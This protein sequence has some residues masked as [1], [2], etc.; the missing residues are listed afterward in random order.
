M[1]PDRGDLRQSAYGPPVASCRSLWMHP[2]AHARTACPNKIKGIPYKIQRGWWTKSRTEQQQHLESNAHRVPELLATTLHDSRRGSLRGRVGSWC[3]VHSCDY[4][5]KGEPGSKGRA[6][7]RSL[8]DGGGASNGNVG[9][10]ERR[11]AL[12]GASRPT[13]ASPSERPPP[14]SPPAAPR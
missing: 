9:R 3:G 1:C 14:V 11:R 7:G 12:L 13:P 10:P 4:W 5:V 6:A 8:P 2:A